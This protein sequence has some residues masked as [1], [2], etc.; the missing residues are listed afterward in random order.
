MKL[1]LIA[2]GFHSKNFNALK[3]YDMEIT[4]I[5]NTNLDDI[6]LNEFDV[7][8]SPSSPIDVSKYPSIKFIFGPHFSVFPDKKQIDLISGNKNVVY[9]QPSEW[10]V[11]LWKCF[12]F[13]NLKIHS[14]PFGVD[15]DKFNE[16][17]H[18]SER[19]EIF[20]YFKRRNKQ[21]LQLI[22][23][24]LQSNQINYKL[25]DYIHKY[26]ET[27]YL[28]CLQNAKCGIWVDAHES[29]GF[30][31]QEA[32]SCNVPLLVWN[33]SSLNQEAGSNY[34][35]FHATTIPYWNDNCGE[36]FYKYDEFFNKYNLF[37]SNLNAYTP[38]QFILDNLSIKKCE[39]KFIDLINNI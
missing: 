5:Y 12:S 23:N 7:I 4:S 14:L 19:K 9:I 32:L 37:L 27:D 15:T 28:N 3:N 29:Q 2:N 26:N 17:K 13:F 20:V 1:L 34:Q 31:L 24:F 16:N 21:E 36:V 33:V 39:E 35:D 6:N 25:F 11:K 22:L 18:I 8:Y 38:R 30:A 10:V